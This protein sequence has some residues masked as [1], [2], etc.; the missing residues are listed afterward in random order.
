MFSFADEV[1]FKLLRE[2]H[3]IFYFLTL[4]LSESSRNIVQLQ[5]KKQNRPLSNVNQQAI[6]MKYM[7]PLSRIKHFKLRLSF[8]F[9][10]YTIHAYCIHLKQF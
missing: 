3:S 6:K 7:A 2:V 1:Y 10:F 8:V 4:R 9:I 5:L